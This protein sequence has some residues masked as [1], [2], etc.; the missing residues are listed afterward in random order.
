MISLSPMPDIKQDEFLRSVTEGLRCPEGGDF[1]R[2]L[3]LL[4]SVPPGD[5]REAFETFLD[6]P[7]PDLAL[8]VARAVGL[9]ELEPAADLLITLVDEPGKWFGHSDRAAIRLEAVHS[10]GLLRAPAAVDSLL[11]IVANSHDSELQ[12]VAVQAIGMI[13]SPVSVRPLIEMMRV[14]P[15][16]ALSAAGALAQI[17]GEEAFRGLVAGLTVDEDMIRSACVWA[18]GKMGDE[19]GVGPLT[20]LIEVSDEFLRRD[21]VWAIGQIGGLRARLC[22]GALSQ[23]DPELGVRREASKA[24]LAGT[25]LRKYRDSST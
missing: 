12:M 3:E 2:T 18:L 6:D 19:R 23:G 9:L 4:R 20:A 11:D 15:P 1:D 7:P 8:G 14:D 5:L 24:I 25:V 17:G 22:L 16:I 10:L 21:I 13:G